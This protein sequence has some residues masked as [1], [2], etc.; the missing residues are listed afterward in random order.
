MSPLSRPAGV[1]FLAQDGMFQSRIDTCCSQTLIV[2]LAH[3]P[4]MS[5]HLSRRQSP[6][7][8]SAQ[9]YRYHGV[10]EAVVGLHDDLGSDL[11]IMALR[12]V[13]GTSFEERTARRTE[14]ACP[15]FCPFTL[16]TKCPE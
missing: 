11:R 6:G 10:G 16:I 8:S 13:C 2:R 12:K 15:A 7:S 1:E 3:L 4:E 14:T 9:H 5:Q